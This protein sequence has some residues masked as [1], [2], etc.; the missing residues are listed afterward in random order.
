MGDE[1]TV[2]TCNPGGGYNFDKSESET[3]TKMKKT[4]EPKQLFRLEDLFEDNLKK[5]QQ[6]TK[7]IVYA[8]SYNYG[9]IMKECHSL[10]ESKAFIK[11]LKEAKYGF[12]LEIYE[13]TIKRVE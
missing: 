7:T 8:V 4:Q 13:L 3:K 6:Q 2:C 11:E 10:E 5:D 9:S 1:N 12:R